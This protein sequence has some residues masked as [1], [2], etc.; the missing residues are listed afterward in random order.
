MMK[1]NDLKKILIETPTVEASNAFKARMVQQLTGLRPASN[2][3]VVIGS[4]AA[5][6]RKKN[7]FQSMILAMMLLAT[8]LVMHDHQ[9]NNHGE[10]DELVPLSTM[11]ELT[12]ST[13]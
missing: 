5:L 3:I 12:L 6:S 10:L 13:L 7:Y 1:D 8:V 2:Q 11:S 4:S 9:L